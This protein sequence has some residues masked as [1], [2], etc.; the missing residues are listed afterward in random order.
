MNQR[1]TRLRPKRLEDAAQDYAWARDPE[2]CELEATFPVSI[3][4]SDYLRIYR[5]ELLHEPKGSQ[6]FAIETIPG[7]HIGN[8]MCYQMD[9]DKREAEVGIL[10]GNRAYWDRGYGTEVMELLLGYVFAHTPVERVYLHTLTWNLRAQRCFAKCGFNPSADESRW[11][12]R[13]V[14]MDID[15]GRWQA[16]QEKTDPPPQGEG[17]PGSAPQA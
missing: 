3:P 15:R 2:L 5:L 12:H 13:F 6:R 4:Y 16:R 1:R 10:I 14:V 9:E 8:C 7:E 11:G 17:G